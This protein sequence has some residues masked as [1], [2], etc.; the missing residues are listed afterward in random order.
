MIR[1]FLRQRAHSL[2]GQ[3]CCSS[4]DRSSVVSGIAVANAITSVSS[5]AALISIRVARA[6]DVARRSAATTRASSTLRR[7][8]GCDGS[9]AHTD[10]QRERVGRI[11]RHAVTLAASRRT[12]AWCPPIASPLRSRASIGG[13]RDATRRGDGDASAISGR[14][15]AK[16]RSTRQSATTCSRSPSARD[17]A[18][19]GALHVAACT[20]PIERQQCRCVDQR[21]GS[22]AKRATRVCLRRRNS[23]RIKRERR[24]TLEHHHTVHDAEERASQRRARR[25]SQCRAMM[26]ADASRAL[27]RATRERI[28]C[29]T[30]GRQCGREPRI[31]AREINQPKR[32]AETHFCTSEIAKR[33]RRRKRD[34]C[35]GRSPDRCSQRIVKARAIGQRL[36]HGATRISPV[37]QSNSSHRQRHEANAE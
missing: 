16:R 13:M 18:V 37:R 35:A 10:Q 19:I 15:T 11:R 29:A 30:R 25:A 23:N 4:G 1:S 33:N 17:A 36:T 27:P 9:R 34:P 7:T 31:G 14:S 21:N 8:C 3:Q 28:A 24:I 12:G 6:D 32:T 22:S 20:H 2:R 26:R 5:F